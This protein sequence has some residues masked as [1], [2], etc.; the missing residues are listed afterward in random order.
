ML[1]AAEVSL[2]VDMSLQATDMTEIKGRGDAI[3][4]A[5]A[6]RLG[7]KKK[8]YYLSEQGNEASTISSFFFCCPLLSGV[9][10]GSWFVSRL[11]ATLSTVQA[12][13][14]STAYSL[15]FVVNN[16][17]K[18]ITLESIRL[19]KIMSD[20]RLGASSSTKGTHSVGKKEDGLYL[21]CE[22]GGG[23]TVTLR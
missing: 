16:I 2:C 4:R 21:Q 1:F 23:N 6:R 17:R 12:L 3:I 11:S 15:A 7:Q 13:T 18:I 10:L 14:E 9:R 5:A 8:I 22:G 20:I 19:P